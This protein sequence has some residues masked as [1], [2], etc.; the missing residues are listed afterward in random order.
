MKKSKLM[1]IIKEELEGVLKEQITL[2]H[3]REQQLHTQGR[4]KAFHLKAGK[5]TP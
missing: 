1:K 4:K 2:V 5:L 3:V